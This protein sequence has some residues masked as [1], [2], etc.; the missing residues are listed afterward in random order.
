M[1][2]IKSL[3]DIEALAETTTVECKLAAG[4]DGQGRLPED[5]WPTYS[6]F[7]NSRGGYIVLGVREKKRQFHLDTGIPNAAKLKDELFDLLHNR[8]KVSASV[9]T[10]DNVVIPVIDGKKIIV[11]EVPRANR[12]QR[13]VFIDQK[14]YGGTYTRGST[15]DRRVDDEV[16]RRW[17]AEQAEESRDARILPGFSIDDLDA[18]TIR[19]F[20]QAMHD[21]NPTQPF[22]SSE[23]EAFLRK[24]KAYGTDR[25]TK[26]NG[27]SAAGLLMFGRHEN[28]VDEFPNYLVDMREFTSGSSALGDEYVRRLTPD[29]TWSGNLFDFYSRAYARLVEDLKVPHVVKAG[30]RKEHDTPVHVAIQEALV[31][32][33]IHADFAGRSAVLVAKWPS[34]FLFRNPGTMR[35]SLEAALSGGD[36]DCRN[37][38]LQQMFFLAGA[39]DKQGAGIPRIYEGWA[40]QHWAP[41]THEED[42]EKE[43]T[44]L[45]LKMVDLIDPAVMSRLKGQFGAAFDGL[46]ANEKAVLACAEVDGEV[47][48]SRAMALC[49][50][51]SFD[52]SRLLQ[53]LTK[54]GLLER[55]GHGPAS[56]Y[57]LAGTVAGLP[58][59]PDGPAPPTSP[60]ALPPTLPP[61]FPLSEG[62]GAMAIMVR[63][64][65]RPT[66]SEIET[67][68]LMVCTGRYFSFRELAALLGRPNP[69]KFRDLYVSKLV[70]EGRLVRKYPEVPGHRDQGYKTTGS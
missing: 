59:T 2:E 14:P 15:G 66:R 60:P 19:R 42:D 39:G 68:I 51:H 47:V 34:A 67:A 64:K 1:L 53:G 44:T 32:S 48:H 40:S 58:L 61:T 26:Q 11:I 46:T 27:V 10:D 8:Q 16:V 12:R 23:G 69:N 30:V 25:E 18:E 45:T 54:R 31:N 29:G 35:V 17:I 57:H 9:I 43:L 41:P 5:F 13:P 20:R 21:R 55:S 22:L 7:A 6:A 70:R 33:L 49:G 56:V 62:A 37:R 65:A 38:L 36:S 4:K 3:Q 63:E 52:A 28:I 50:L 24:I